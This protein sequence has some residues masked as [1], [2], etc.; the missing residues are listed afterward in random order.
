MDNES[1]TSSNDCLLL[2]VSGG[3]NISSLI[4]FEHPEW[5]DDVVRNKDGTVKHPFDMMNIY[6]EICLGV[7]CWFGF[8]LNFE[9]ILRIIYDRNLRRK[10]QYIFQLSI[11]HFR[12]FSLYFQSPLKLPV[13]YFIGPVMTKYV[14]FTCSSV[15]GLIAVF[16][17]IFSCL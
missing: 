3:N 12:V 11:Q 2:A 14:A 1:S 8:P 7:L 6:V 15:V 13:S 5:G 16:C 17:L 4:V 9:V 10:P